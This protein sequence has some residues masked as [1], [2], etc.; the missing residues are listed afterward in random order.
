MKSQPGT[1]ISTLKLSRAVTY[2][3]MVLI[4]FGLV[5]LSVQGP[6]GS[7]NGQEIAFFEDFWLHGMYPG[8]GTPG[9]LQLLDDG[10]LLMSFDKNW[11]VYGRYSND[12]GKTWGNEFILAPP[13]GSSSS[14]CDVHSSFVETAN[15]DLLMTF[16]RYYFGT[17][18]VYKE[19]YYRRSPDGG[20][21]WDSPTLMAYDGLFNDKPLLLSS[22]RLI[23]PVEREAE[24]GTS[25][26]RGYVS[27][28]WYSD[29]NGQ[30][31]TKSANEVNMLPTEAQEPHVVELNDGRL[32]M[33]MRTY[34]GYLVRSYSTD[35]GT[36]WSAGEP[37]TNLIISADS[38]AISVKRI[39]ST[40][41]LLLLR[42]TGGTAPARTP[43]VSAISTDDGLT[44]SNE[45]VIAG[46]SWET[47]GYPG[48]QF[49]DDMALIG[50]MSTQGGRLARIGIDWFYKTDEH[51]GNADP[52]TEGWTFDDFNN[53]TGTQSAGVDSEKYWRIQRDAGAAGRYLHSLNESHL[54]DS[55]GWTMT[56]RVKVNIA[57]WINDCELAVMDGTSYWSL[58]LAADTEGYMGAYTL[59]S[60]YGV[61]SAL[62]TLDP[63]LDY[64]TYQIIFDPLSDAVTYYIDGE[65]IGGQARTD[66]GGCWDIMRAQFGDT[67][68]LNA[69][70]SQWS[71]VSFEIGQNIWKPD[72]GDANGDGK[73]D[74]RDAAALA[75]N[76][77]A[78]GA[79]WSQGDFNNDGIVDDRDAVILAANWNHG[80]EQTASTPEPGGP[81]GLAAVLIAAGLVI[82][83]KRRVAT[84]CVILSSLLWSA[85]SGSAD[86]AK[87]SSGKA[88]VFEDILLAEK[89]PGI[90]SPGDLQ[91]LD[92][93][94]LLMSF[95]KDWGVY[96]RYSDDLGKTWGPECTLAARPQPHAD[97]C[98]V[99]SSFIEAANGDLLLFYQYY[100][101]GTRPVYKVNYYRRSLDGGKTWGDQLA[102]G[103]DGLFNDK[104]IRL[105]SGRLIAPVEREAEI[106]DSDHRGYVSYVYYSDDNGYSWR[107]SSNE[108][109]VLPVE[110][111]EPHVVEL[112]DGRLMMFCRTYSGYVLRSYSTDKG[113]TWSKGEPVKDLILSQDS[114]ALSL[115]R[116]PA[117][118]DLLLLRTTGGTAP[119]RTPL[120]SAISSDD[121][122]TWEHERVIAGDPTEIYGYPGVQFTDKLALIGFSSRKGAHLARISINWFYVR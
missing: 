103:N 94:R 27:Y 112:K 72:P 78:S 15:G 29:D 95:D 90:G 46:V 22:G 4:V 59:N 23:A 89:Y 43:L 8:I 81:V 71:Y 91:L 53:G 79:I 9:D 69:S 18:P 33:L 111:Q 28:T 80:V 10:R 39:P 65:A 42:T 70:D 75:K 118:G 115:K 117:T 96:A 76:W 34:S 86:D 77:L 93:G 84:C 14:Y 35:Q 106:G 1:Y 101:Y 97:H 52:A 58:N 120:V 48:V 6:L 99:H 19:V 102:M 45:R 60:S 88:T 100:V 66:V 119:N 17:R 16:Q 109:N 67:N 105:E 13:P 44:W 82:F 40:G 54:D 85:S 37:L 108:V 63:S 56:A 25:D 49:T 122:A 11:G 92:D 98:Y 7:A 61:D 57:D 87:D 62:S 38:S 50:Y 5:M 110:A 24:I 47:Y 3:P 83:R 114:S 68:G 55:S 26:H 41:D 30:S 121:G 74:E 21:T 104:L 20:D 31:W 51:V 73:V 12:L 116:I 32:M 113:V 36:S 2:S 107:K 64:H